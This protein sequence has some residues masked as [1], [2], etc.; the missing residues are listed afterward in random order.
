MGCCAP[1]MT[2]GCCGGSN[3]HDASPV[4]GSFAD[5]VIQHEDPAPVVPVSDPELPTPVEEIFEQVVE[6]IIEP[7]EP[8]QPEEPIVEI[9]EKIAEEEEEEEGE[10]VDFKI[11]EDDPTP[12]FFN[13]EDEV[14]P[15]EPEE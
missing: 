15:E 14:T 9:I 13:L 11:N 6:E 10:T 7:A 8:E 1:M 4:E 12:S 5:D 3:Q 2:M